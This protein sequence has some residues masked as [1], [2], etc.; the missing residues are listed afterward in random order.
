[1][2][3]E[4]IQAANARPAVGRQLFIVPSQPVKEAA[5]FRIVPS[6]MGNA[7]AR[8]LRARVYASISNELVE[9]GKSSPVVVDGDQAKAVIADEHRCYCIACAI[10]FGCSTGRFSQKNDLAIG[11][12]PKQGFE[13]QGFRI[14]KLFCG[15][16]NLIGQIALCARKGQL[17]SDVRTVIGAG[18]S[19]D[20]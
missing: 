1:M 5:C 3:T 8:D 9:S 18:R 13:F 17:M 16:R 6:P 7:A 11:I 12:R 19:A 10:E 14:W 15:L 2:Q 20:G 4:G